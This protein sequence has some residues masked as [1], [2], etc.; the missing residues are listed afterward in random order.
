MKSNSRI[1]VPTDFS[2]IAKNAFLYAVALASEMGGSVTVLHTFRS[3]LGVP[4]MDNVA[5]EILEGRRKAAEAELKEFVHT[6]YPEKVDIQTRL[7]S[8]LP[9]DV[10]AVLTTNGEYDMVVM[11][12]H[13]EHNWLEYAFGSFTSTA[14]RDAACIVV[15]VPEN[16]IY[17]PTE[18]IAL[19]TD[20]HEYSLHGA[21]EALELARQNKA[22]LHCI[23][24]SLHDSRHN[25]VALQN[26]N[27]FLQIN[28]Q[29][30]EFKLYDHNAESVPQGLRNFIKDEGIDI[31]LMVR[32]KRGFF[33]QLFHRS[34]TN[35]MILQPTVPT[36]II[37]ADIK[38]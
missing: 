16:Y 32:P 34:Q 25:A 38:S 2:P 21:L 10:L 31:L 17:Q 22:E 14:V 37:P 8:G 29:G 1:L 12:T 28:A 36:W 23:H 27:E 30:V 35:E 13:R 11:G 5:E 26:L 19:A 7:E 15:A 24:I 18:D 4:A 9:N 6:G 33:E 20:L 3:D